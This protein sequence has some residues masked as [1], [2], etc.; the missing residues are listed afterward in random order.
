MSNTKK[1]FPTYFHFSYCD[2]NG[3]CV[4]TVVMMLKQCLSAMQHPFEGVKEQVKVKQKST[5]HLLVILYKIMC[6]RNK[7]IEE[8]QKNI[9]TCAF[10]YTVLS[11]SLMKCIAYSY[12]ITDCF[13]AHVTIKTGQ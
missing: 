10:G 9:V 11:R 8:K 2:H 13:E 12:S 3:V 5:L 1:F 7:R 6:P 4:I